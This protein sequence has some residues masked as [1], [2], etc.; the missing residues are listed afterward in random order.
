VLKEKTDNHKMTTEQLEGA[1]APAK[2]AYEAEP[3]SFVKLAGIYMLQ[4]CYSKYVRGDNTPEYAKYLGYL[5][6]RDL[7]PDFKP[8]TYREFLKELLNGKGMKPYPDMS[9]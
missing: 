5:D 8:V 4:Y 6:A 7:Y 9:W 3:T 1:I 2:A